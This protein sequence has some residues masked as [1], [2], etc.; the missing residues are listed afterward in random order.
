MPGRNYP[1][2]IDACAS[3]AQGSITPPIF[4]KWAALSAIAGA[5]GRRCWYDAGEY[6]VRPNL[7]TVLVAPP[8]FGKSV[9][10]ILPYDKVFR[11][12]TE[13]LIGRPCVGAVRA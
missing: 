12:L 4:R 2:W 5:L 10:L 13:P 11:K 1:D 3:A 8:G 6:K 7:Y 9:G